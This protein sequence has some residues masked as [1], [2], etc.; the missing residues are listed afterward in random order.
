MKTNAHDGDRL[1]Y[2]VAAAVVVCGLRV[3]FPVILLCFWP[4]KINFYHYFPSAKVMIGSFLFCFPAII[5][6]V[7]MVLLWYRRVLTWLVVV[8]VGLV[9]LFCLF[10]LLLIL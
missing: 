8:P 7:L 4:L 1:S 10:L 3:V 6:A 2:L 9:C 5:F